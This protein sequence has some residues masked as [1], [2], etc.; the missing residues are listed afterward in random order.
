M[1]LIYLQQDLRLSLGEFLAV[2]VEH[3]LMTNLKKMMI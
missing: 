3:N 2:S 1:I